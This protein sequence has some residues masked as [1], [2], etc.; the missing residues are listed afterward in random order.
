MIHDLKIFRDPG[1]TWTI[2]WYL[3]FYHYWGLIYMILSGE[4]S[5]WLELSIKS[6]LVVRFE[7]W[8]LHSAFHDFQFIIRTFCFWQKSI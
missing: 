5:E 1:G 8:S 7:I 2:Y 4:S 6:D 3:W